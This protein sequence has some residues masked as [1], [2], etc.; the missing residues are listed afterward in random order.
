MSTLPPAASHSR[1]WVSLTSRLVVTAV[2]LVAVVCLLSGVLTV[3]AMR[4][5]LMDRLDD[6]VRRLPTSISSPDTHNHGP[7]TLLALIPL[8]SFTPAQ[9]GVLTDVSGEFRGLSD[10]A[11]DALLTVPRDGR[12][13]TRRVP[14]FGGYRVIVRRGTSGQTESM[15][16]V[17]GLPTADVESTLHNL[18][19][20]G[21]L[22]T[23][24]SVAVAGAIGV[25][26]VRRQLRP[27]REVAGTAHAVAALPL[28]SGAIEMTVR[29]PAH[30]T[31]EESEVGQVGAA[32]NTL[33]Q[34]VE[35]SLR[36][37]HRSEQQV[38]QFVA[39]ASHEL[40]TP[41]TTIRGY[42]ELAA[43]RPDDEQ[44]TKTALAKVQ[45]E[46]GRMSALVEDLL[47]L[48]R[49]DS[50]RA[51][52]RHRVDLTQLCFEAVSDARV[53]GPLHRWRLVL[54]ADG[55]PE[56]PAP[57]HVTGDP[58]RLHQV[59]TN[60]LTNARKHTPPG[61]TVTVSVQP[62]GFSVHDDGPGFPPELIDHAFERFSRGD[63]SRH[64]EHR[65][66]GA[67]LG[68]SLVQAIVT[69]HGGMV[70]LDSRPGST[71]LGVHLPD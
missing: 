21:A 47:L 56:E 1:G 51:L 50:G 20:W 16:Q 35:A 41:L 36:V 64:R 66:G 23:L 28:A 59:I 26:V 31:D 52:E 67:G 40:R 11:T 58:L 25:V 61:T 37:R 27:L 34:H 14:G 32:L 65:D 39:D 19:G 29:V 62:G 8:N 63:Q 22:L 33:I 69:S 5:F 18:V 71:T 30:L 13:H 48:A 10:T 53:I 12:V 2:T 54:P 42:T 70:T 45:E 24:L 43:G 9:G 57:V 46:A 4:G 3:V 17:S 68:L 49:L 38:R 15:L 55:D 7:G 60:L 44:A 6:D